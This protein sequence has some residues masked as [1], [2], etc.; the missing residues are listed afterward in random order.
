MKPTREGLGMMAAVGEGRP[1]GTAERGPK[2]PARRNLSPWG[3]DKAHV[4]KAGCVYSREEKKRVTG[5][6]FLF[7][8][9]VGVMLIIKGFIWHAGRFLTRGIGENHKYAVICDQICHEGLFRKKCCLTF[10]MASRYD[11]LLLNSPRSGK[12]QG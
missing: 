12:K 4:G 5:I 3:L 6:F 10:V 1:W 8:G 11:Q 7:S 2:K 9:A